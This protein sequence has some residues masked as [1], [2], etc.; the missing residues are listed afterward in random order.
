MQ[1][2]YPVVWVLMFSVNLQL[3]NEE[4]ESIRIYFCNKGAKTDYTVCIDNINRRHFILEVLLLL[5]LLKYFCLYNIY[6]SA[7]S[8]SKFELFLGTGRFM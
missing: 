8:T 6:T 4:N 5:S 3:L 7:E 2:V 1:I